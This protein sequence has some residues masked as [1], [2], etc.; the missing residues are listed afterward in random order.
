MASIYKRGNIWWI[1]YY[2]NGKPYCKSLKTKDKKVA[3]YYKN[4]KE[5]ELAE[6]RSPLP[7]ENVSAQDCLDEYAKATKHQKTLRTLK[8]DKSRIQAF[9]KYSK[10]QKVDQIKLKTI[11]DYINYRL[12]NTPIGHNTAN[13]II[14]SIKTWLNWAKRQGYIIDNPATKIKKFRL[15]KNPP[16]FLNDEQVESLLDTAKGSYLYPMIATAIY[17]GLRVKELMYLEWNDIDFEKNIIRII[18]KDS[19]SPK[20]KKF[21]IIPLN[22]K[23]KSILKPHRKNTGWCFTNEGKKWRYPPRKSF[24][25]ILEE[26]NLKNVGWH[27]LRRTFASRLAMRGVSLLKIAKWLG[28]SDPR[29]TFQ[30][31]A[32]LAPSSD[33]EINKL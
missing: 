13:H 4:Q 9:L 18:N 20:S 17:A 6:R 32:H 1:K 5:I 11:E 24:K 14:G 8:D 15:P 27:D 23:L 7:P 3:T 22:N 31:Y 19:F 33:K 25:T 30:T 26:A 29:I 16:V 10:V 28:H 2:Q 21:R 12:E